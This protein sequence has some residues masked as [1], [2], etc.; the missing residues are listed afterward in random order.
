MGSKLDIDSLNIPYGNYDVPFDIKPFIDRIPEYRE[1]P[2]KKISG[3]E[4]NN[5]FIDI[6]FNKIY[7]KHIIKIFI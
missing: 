5:Y 1:Q 4:L 2:R 6:C 3:L 7:S